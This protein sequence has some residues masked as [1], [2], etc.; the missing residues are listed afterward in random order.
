MPDLTREMRQNS[1]F[2]TWAAMHKNTA[3]PTVRRTMA[4]D[5]YAANNV[6]SP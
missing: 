4:R 6:L 3:G 1:E 5:R 2:S